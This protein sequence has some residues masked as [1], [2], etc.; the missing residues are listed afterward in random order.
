MKKPNRLRDASLMFRVTEAEKAAIFAKMKAGNLSDFSKFAR[1]MLMHGNVVIIENFEQVA[2][3]KML[4][5]LGKIGSNVN[6][7]AR[8]MNTTGALYKSEVDELMMNQA[9]INTHLREL[10]KIHQAKGRC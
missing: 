8:F 5:D 6:Q 2:L 1:E 3:K 4:A 10:I 7:V 9:L